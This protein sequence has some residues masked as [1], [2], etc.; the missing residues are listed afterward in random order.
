M[1]RTGRCE[2]D[3]GWGGA[4]CD[5]GEAVNINLVVSKQALRSR[6]RLIC[7]I[8]ICSLHSGLH[9]CSNLNCPANSR[10]VNET[11]TLECICNVGYEK[12]GLNNSCAEIN[13]CLAHGLC[14]QFAICNKTGPGLMLKV[15]L[16]IQT[17]F[18]A[19]DQA[20]SVLRKIEANLIFDQFTH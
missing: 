15:D 8:E 12:T 19:P 9:D 7:L 5:V 6:S 11:G 3:S 14:H 2:C 4:L 20:L 13:P 16:F 1:D 10:C 17:N 18:K